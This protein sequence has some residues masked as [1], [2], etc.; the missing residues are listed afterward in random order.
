MNTFNKFMGSLSVGSL[1]IASLF[2]T[3]TANAQND[4]SNT[5]VD[6]N[7]EIS[8]APNSTCGGPPPDTGDYDDCCQ[9]H[10][11]HDHISGLVLR[12][13]GPTS[14]ASIEFS[15]DGYSNTS[16]TAT[17]SLNDVFLIEADDR[18]GTN[19]YMAIN[20]A[21]FSVHTSCSDPTNVGYGISTDGTF[22]PNPNENDSDIVFIIEGLATANDGWCGADNSSSSCNGTAVFYINDSNGFSLSDYSFLWEDGSTAN[23]RDDLCAGTYSVTVSANG[24]DDSS[25]FVFTIVDTPATIEIEITTDANSV[26]DEQTGENNCNCNGYIQEFFFMYTGTPGIEGGAHDQHHDNEYG[27]WSSLENNVVYSFIVDSDNHQD[28]YHHHNDPEFWTN[29]GGWV[30]YGYVDHSCAVDVVGLSFGPF[31]IV[32]YTDINGNECL[33]FSINCNGSADV[34]AFNGEAPYT[35]LWSDGSTSEDRDDLCAGTY[36]V[37]V[38]DYNGCSNTLY[39]VEIEGPC[40]CDGNVLDECGVCGGDNSTCL[41]CCGVVNGDGTTCD[42]GCGACNDDT[43]CEDDCPDGWSYCGEGTTWD[44][45]SKNCVC[46]TSCYGDLFPDGLIQ[47][48]D[49]LELLGVYGTSCD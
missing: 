43:S 17:H 3:L 49:L 28:Q 32:G 33:P 30:S 29:D 41:D 8:T 37:T 39:F 10:G 26:C 18:F 2:F 11:D 48:K 13:V 35:Y 44:P 24:I 15:T 34:T 40:D 27:N 38:T 45:V 42:G 23:H 4:G 12:Y 6:D 7:V 16:Y 47:L 9:D 19:S 5:G 21:W 25:V 31:T 20:G 14:P 36:H 22:V 46:V 1:F